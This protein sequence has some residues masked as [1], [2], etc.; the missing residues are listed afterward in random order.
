MRNFLEK[1]FKLGQRNTTIKIE[2]IA[3]VTTFM[4]MSYII[5]VQPVVLS[6]AGIDF[7]AGL[8]ATCVGSAVGSVIMAL[9]A[10]YPIALA[11]G[12]GENFFF[13]YTV[14]KGMG[15]SWQSALAIVFISGV[16]FSV[17]SLVKL[18]EAV[19]DAMPT[20]L[21]NSIATG[22]GLFIALIGFIQTGIIKINPET[23]LPQLG[24]IY[25][26]EVVI[27]IVGLI[28]TSILL[29]RGIKGSI[30]IGIIFSTIL[31]IILGV[32]KFDGRIFSLPEVKEPAFTT[33]HKTT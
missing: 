12:M 6:H 10:N 11:P 9:L 16:L 25:K 15:L 20:C 23:H 4:T 18:R 22:I 32:V 1:V 19:I 14:V 5:F 7:G 31:A 8:I 26:I 28:F 21:K 17:L 30:L 24:E 3:G 13:S 2:F 29:G 27:S 33:K